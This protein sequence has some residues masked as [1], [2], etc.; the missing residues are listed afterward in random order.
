MIDTLATN[1]LKNG[2]EK[3]TV[4]FSNPFYPTKNYLYLNIKVAKN[5]KHARLF[6]FVTSLYLTFDH[7]LV[8]KASIIT[9]L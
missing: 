9:L 1:Q 7:S 5:R 3:P 8:A 6:Y 4:G 2:F